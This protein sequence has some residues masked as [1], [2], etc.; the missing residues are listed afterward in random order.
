MRAAC[1]R[2]HAAPGSPSP[3][4]SGHSTKTRASS[5]YGSR[6]PHS[7]SDTPANRYRSR[8]ATPDAALVAVADREG[9]AGD[10][11]LD[12]ERA[13]RTAD[14]RRL[15]GA[16]LAGDGDDVA[17]RERLR[18]AGCELLGLLRRV[19][20]EGHGPRLGSVAWTAGP[21]SAWKGVASCSSRSPRSTRTAS[22]RRR[23]TRRRGGGC[24]CAEPATRDAF[25]RFL[26]DALARRRRGTE[27][28]FA[29]V[30]D[31]RVVGSTRYLALAPEFRRLE[32]G[33]TWLHPSVWGRG[34]NVEA[35]LLQLGGRVRPPRVPA[36]RA[37]D[38]RAQRALAGGAGRAP[39]A[40]RGRVPQAHARP[41][42]REPRLGVVRDR[43]RR[44]ARGAREPERRLESNQVT[45]CYLSPSP[46]LSKALAPLGRAGSQR[47]PSRGTRI[48]TVT[49]RCSAETVF[50]PERPPRRAR[51]QA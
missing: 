41:G 4:A 17:R 18:Q 29:T 7:A 33:W 1:A 30:V 22:G 23:G 28:P 42:R 2:A 21:A 38:G 15:P 37:E 13:R 46:F 19:G 34:V 32:I 49:K 24:R 16:E 26:D 8:C 44:L 9:R 5:K 39:G 36:R 25:R 51:A 35:K 45:V 3:A 20:V 27:I 48:P 14:E 43:R 40:V 31:G 10:A 47:A 11:T 50:W 12:P 6:S